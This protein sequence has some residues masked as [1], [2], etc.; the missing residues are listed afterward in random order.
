MKSKDKNRHFIRTYSPNPTQSNHVTNQYTALAYDTDGDNDKEWHVDATVH[1]SNITRHET[2]PRVPVPSVLMNPLQPTII[3]APT[4]H[5]ALQALFRNE[6]I[7][8]KEKSNSYI[9]MQ[10][11][12]AISNSGALGHILIKG[13]P[14]VN[15]R[16]AKNPMTITLPSSSTITSTYTYNLDIPWLPDHVTEAHIVPGLAH[17]SLILTHKFC[18]A[19]CQVAFDKDECRVYHK[20][21][22]A[23]VR[24]QCPT[25]DLCL[26]PIH[27]QHKATGVNQ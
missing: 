10:V 19:G 12:Y 18:A 23:L 17:V 24:E 22:L 7:K 4:R 27:P 26:I 20:G 2:R 6:N 13:V 9:S 21:K 14:V 8:W 11:Q 16:P 15:K 25:T 3:S 1:M 5:K